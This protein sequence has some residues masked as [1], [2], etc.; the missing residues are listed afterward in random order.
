MGEWRRLHPE[1]VDGGVCVWMQ[2]KDKRMVRREKR[3]RKAFMK[4]ELAGLSMIGE[5]DDRRDGLF[6][7]TE[8]KSKGSS[9]VNSTGD[10]H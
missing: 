9:N 2:K 10:E 5:N 3:R 8:E 7:T 6:L 4:A 1:D